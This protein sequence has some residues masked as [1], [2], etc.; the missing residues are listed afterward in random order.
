MLLHGLT[1]V[2][3]PSAGE[4]MQTTSVDTMQR[5][6][7]HEGLGSRLSSHLSAEVHTAR[8]PVV[9]TDLGQWIWNAA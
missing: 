9:Q 5:W 2:P 8:R 4:S 6:S 3:L 1:L 7:S